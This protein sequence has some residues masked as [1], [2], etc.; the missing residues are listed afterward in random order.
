MLRRAD[1]PAD[2]RG[3][4]LGT[5]TCGSTPRT[6]SRTAGCSAG[7]RRRAAPS[8]CDVAVV[9]LPRISNATDAEALATEP[10]VRVR[11]TVE[12]AEL[13]DADLVVLPGSKSTVDDLAWLRRDGLADAV[14]AHA[15]AGQAAARHLRRLPD[16]RPSDPRRRWRAGAGSVA[17]LGLLPV[18]VTFAA[19]QDAR[20]VGRAPRC[21]GVPVRGYEIHHG[22]VSHGRPGAD[23]AADATPTAAGE[24]AVVGNVFGTHWHGAFESDGFRRR[25]L[26][27][28]GPAGRPARLPG[29]PGHR[30]SPPPASAPWTCSAT[31]SRSTW[32]PTRCGGSSSPAHPPACP[33]SHPEPR[34]PPDHQVR[35]RTSADPHRRRPPTA[36]GPRRTPAPA[37]PAAR[38]APTPRPPRHRHARGGDQ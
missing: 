32:T 29:R 9:R 16:A 3:A 10:G 7:R 27:R 35:P 30:A 19:A 26:D 17:G 24:G 14:L 33:S 34:K 36:G 28:G 31:W 21:G 18:E 23:A 22:Y 38:R 15:A 12:P 1:R 37:T 4:A 2:V 20:P 25:F 13:A 8:G 5:S 6:R 11:L